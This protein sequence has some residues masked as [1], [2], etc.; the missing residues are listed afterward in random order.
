MI[1]YFDTSALIK[2]YIEEIGSDT[3]KTLLDDADEVYVSEICIIECMSTTRRLWK[4]KLITESE[5][6]LLKKEI[7]K[8]YPYFKKV[9]LDT[10]HENAEKLIDT[11]QLKSLD[12]IQLGSALSVKEIIDNFVCCDRKLRDSAAHERLNVINP[13]EE[14]IS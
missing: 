14:T 10:V 1:C 3:V 12:S 7:K 9:A 6:R 13:I 5:Y 4:E 11:Y 2:N 8:D